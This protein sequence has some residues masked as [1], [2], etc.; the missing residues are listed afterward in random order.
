MNSTNEAENIQ[1][2]SGE[3]SFGPGQINYEFYCGCFYPL[4]GYDFTERLIL[5][6]TGSELL[7]NVMVIITED[8]KNIHPMND[9]Q[10][11]LGNLVP[12]VSDTCF[13]IFHLKM[14]APAGGT[15]CEFHVEVFSNQVFYDSVSFSQDFASYCPPIYPMDCTWGDGVYSFVFQQIENLESGC[16]EDGYEFFYDYQAFLNVGESYLFSVMSMYSDNRASLWIDL[17]NDLIFIPSDLMVYNL[18]LET[19]GVFYDSVLTIPEIIFPGE[20]RLRITAC[21]NSPPDNTTTCTTYY[22]EAEDYRIWIFN[23]SIAPPVSIFSAVVVQ[24]NIV[25]LYWSPPI[26]PI[27][28]LMNYNIYRDSIFLTALEPSALAYIETN[29]PVGMHTYCVEVEYFDTFSRPV[30]EDVEVLVGIKEI[31][32]GSIKIFP[33]PASD[34]VGIKSQEN[35]SR[36]MIYNLFGKLLMEIEPEKKYIELNCKT[37]VNGMYIV[38]IITEKDET[39]VKI[40]LQGE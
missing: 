6:Y 28:D 38:K 21:W 34:F 9:N 30:C 29:V 27:F 4:P 13:F 37:L 33:N 39:N 14:S 16:S 8:C 3:N 19:P 11:F 12:F 24:E 25:E 7:E 35:I 5:Q 31:P 32:E 40:I 23:D 20:K 26:N 2:S 22:G 10:V 17:D 15:Y 18:V 36:I 1:V